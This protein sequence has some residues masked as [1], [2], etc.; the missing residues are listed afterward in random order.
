[1]TKAARRALAANRDAPQSLAL[2]PQLRVRAA[3]GV[4]SARR[5]RYGGAVGALDQIVCSAC[6]D[7][8]E[9]LLALLIADGCALV[10]ASTADC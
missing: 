8:S 4:R 7:A 1:M 9:V 5:R 2:L 10:V 3:C 6:T